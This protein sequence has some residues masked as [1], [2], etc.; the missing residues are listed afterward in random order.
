VAADPRQDPPGTSTSFPF[1][2]ESLRHLVRAARIGQR[3]ALGH[4]RVDLVLTEQLEER[5]E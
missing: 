1:A 2:A 4:D 5:A 3:Q